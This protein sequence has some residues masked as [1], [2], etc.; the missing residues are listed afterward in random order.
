[1][2]FDTKKIKQDAKENFEKA[3]LETANLL[4][5]ESKKD[6]TLGKGP[7]QEHPLHNLV[8]DV[9]RIFIKFGFSEVENQIFISEED[10]YKQYG[11]EAPVILDRVYY[12]GGLPRPDIGLGD[13]KILEMKNIAP[14]INV[15]NFKKILRGYREGSIE[16]DNLLE[17][18]VDKLKIKTEQAT[19]IINL[20]PEFRNIEPVC[21]KQTLRSHMTGAWFPTLEALQDSE[22]PLKLF[23]IGLRFRREQKLDATHLRAHYGASCVIMDEDISNEA[24][25]KL[26][27]KIM[28][29]LNFLDINFIKKKAT[30]NY[31]APDME[32]EIF[33]GNIEVADCGMYSPVA[34][35]N[36][37][38]NVPVFNL[39][40]GLERV[41]MIRDKIGDVRELLYPQFYRNVS[42]SDEELAGHVKIS[43]EPVTDDGR[44]L[45]EKIS[46]TAKT[47]A[48]VISP[49]RF[50]AYEGEFM[51]K[52][53]KVSVVE[54]EENTKLLGPAAL[55]DIYVHEGNIYGIPKDAGKLSSELVGVTEKGIKVKFSVLGAISEG[56]AANI[57]DMI[58][59]GKNTGL[60]QFKMAKTPADLNVEITKTARR[61]ITSLNKKII[62]KGPVFMSVEFETE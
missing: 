5:Q 13:E 1:M 27:E 37:D 38:I 48:D 40:F 52:F 43:K 12:L 7:G 20:F 47:H 15:G 59:A 55:N 35:A 19:G 45:A 17:I 50:T 60:I 56:I 26:T 62:L 58:K 25:K 24:G 21:S 61:F 22:L 51:G 4:P 11:P 18:M 10:V 34:L 36:Y 44:K 16:G 32:Y 41:L 46:G 54:K 23:S 9:R 39:G 29:E 53:I 6:Y 28:N 30:S 57:E 42:L 33:S 2:R 3:W 8:Q 31:Y 14:F 49:C